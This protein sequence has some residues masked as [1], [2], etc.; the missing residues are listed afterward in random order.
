MAALNEVLEAAGGT[1]RRSAGTIGRDEAQCRRRS[2]HRSRSALRQCDSRAAAQNS[3]GMEDTFQR[4]NFR[5]DMLERDDQLVKSKGHWTP[6][7]V[8]STLLLP[9]YLV[10][11]RCQA[12]LQIQKVLP[13]SSRKG[14]VL[15][16]IHGWITDAGGPAPPS[17]LGYNGIAAGSYVLYCTVM[18]PRACES[19]WSEP[20]LPSS[21]GGMAGTD[22]SSECTV[23]TRSVGTCLGRSS[24]NT[25]PVNST[26]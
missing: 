1:R 23:P 22:L 3:N 24:I 17:Y 12:E 25:V 14:T 26:P 2:C 4:G 19:A 5:L 11:S 20:V 15:Y 13:G 9:P 6:G 21:V 16:I 10:R 7:D 18:D 8:A